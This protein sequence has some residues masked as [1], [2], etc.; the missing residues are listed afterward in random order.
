MFPNHPTKEHKKASPGK[1]NK[2]RHHGEE[3]ENLE[4]WLVSYAD[5]ITLLFAFFVTM[6]AVSRADGQK[7]GSALESV[8]KAL[9]S[10]IPL[11]LSAKDPGVFPNQTV[12]IRFGLPLIEGRNYDQALIQIGE[13][14]KKG[15]ED[16]SIRNN[17]QGISSLKDQIQFILEDRGLVIRIPEQIFFNSG[18]ASIR[19]EMKPIL[20]L[21]GQILKNVPNHIRIEGHTDNIPINTYKF[22]SNWELSAAR[23]TTIVRYLLEH[24]QYDPERISAVGYGE[25]RPVATNENP[26]GR[27]KNR[28][29]DF[30]ILSNKEIDSE[31]PSEKL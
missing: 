25:F 21:L 18:E 3:H 14:I 30:V 31:L 7:M 17:H 24:F 13:Q 20:D 19:P 26:E 23:A 27:S 10:V 22:P 2:K 29:V 12:P 4:R 6:Y 28:R 16:A 5:F 15:I 9:G 1:P 11:H 8:Q